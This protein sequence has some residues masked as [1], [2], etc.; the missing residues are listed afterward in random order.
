MRIALLVAAGSLV[1]ENME[2][3]PSTL[4][5]GVPAKPRRAVAPEEQE[6]FREGVKSYVEKAR[7]YKDDAN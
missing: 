7:L 6:R 1:P 3:P 4:V 2:V 5:M